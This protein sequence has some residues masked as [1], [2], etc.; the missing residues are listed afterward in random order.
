[1]L[2]LLAFD[3][4]VDFN[5]YFAARQRSSTA[6]STSRQW[7]SAKIRKIRKCYDQQFRLFYIEDCYGLVVK[8]SILIDS[9]F[10]PDLARW[11]FFNAN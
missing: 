6:V 11:L 8:V 10:D 5:E 1:M 7:V 9:T 2:T 4:F 3:I